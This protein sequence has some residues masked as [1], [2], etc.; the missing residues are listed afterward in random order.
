MFWRM[1]SAVYAI[2]RKNLICDREQAYTPVVGAYFGF[3]PF[4]GRA[5]NTEVAIVEHTFL[6]P[7]FVNM[8][9]QAPTSSLPMVF[10]NS[11]CRPSEPAALL[12]LSRKIA[13]WTS[14]FLGGRI[15][16]PSSFIEFG[17]SSSL[18]VELV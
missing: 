1:A 2:D 11:A 3:S 6:Q 5:E 14:S 9:V 13:T 10:N 18:D 4:R 7:Y 17:T 16:M 8:L 15:S 12:F